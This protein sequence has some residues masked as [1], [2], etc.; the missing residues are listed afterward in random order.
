MGAARA[1]RGCMSSTTPQFIGGVIESDRPEVPLS[2]LG[3][4]GRLRAS[5]YA[6]ALPAAQSCRN[7]R[8]SLLP[9]TSS[10]WQTLRLYGRPSWI[11]SPPRFRDRISRKKRRPN[12]HRRPL[13]GPFAN[14]VSGC[15]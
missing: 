1:S 10:A 5:L 7:G 2:G 4:C 9:P 8:P 13:A 12:D 11:R 14:L 3:V 15:E 6:G